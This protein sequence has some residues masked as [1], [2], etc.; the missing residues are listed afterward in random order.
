MQEKQSAKP[1][2]QREAIAVKL[3]K[4]VRAIDVPG[5]NATEG[6]VVKN[7]TNQDRWEV[8]F[9]PWLRSFEVRFFPANKESAPRAAFVPESQVA[10]W[11]PL[12]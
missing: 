4:F 6:I 9:L 10:I 8:S 1:A 3:I 11:E 7:P 2:A 5:R 12:L